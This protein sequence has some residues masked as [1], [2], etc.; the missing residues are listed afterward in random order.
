M[1]CF[2]S[3]VILPV[4]PQKN[5]I[6]FFQAF[7]FILQGPEVVIELE[8]WSAAIRKINACLKLQT[9]LGRG[10]KGIKMVMQIFVNIILEA[11]IF[12]Y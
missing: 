3:S 1:S 7:L 9:E 4:Y 5:A 11:F 12:I 6:L 2:C 10:G 8:I